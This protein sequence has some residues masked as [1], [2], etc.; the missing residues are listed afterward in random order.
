MRTAITTRA[1]ASRPTTPAVHIRVRLAAFLTTMLT[2]GGILLTAYGI[3]IGQ[4]LLISFAIISLLN[5]TGEL[6]SWLRAPFNSPHRWIDLF[7]S[8]P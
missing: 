3:A 7:P 1:P 8:S 2:S 6:P 4:A 5:G